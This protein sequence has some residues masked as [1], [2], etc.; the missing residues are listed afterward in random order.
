MK[1]YFTYLAAGLALILMAQSARGQATPEARAAALTAIRQ[2][3]AG[4]GDVDAV[5]GKIAAARALRGEAGFDRDLARLEEL[6]TY[7]LRFWEHAEG[8]TKGLKGTEELV[9]GEQRVAV[10]ESA[11]GILVLRVAGQNKS[12]TR[13]TMPARLVLT[14]A[15][16]EL[17]AAD[18][19]TKVHIGAFLAL[20]GRGDRKL[21]RQYWDEAAKAGLDV[22]RL[23][24]ELDVPQPPLPA[25]P[26]PMSPALR[27]QLA[28]RNFALRR[29]SG[30][31]WTREPSG[32]V[33]TQNAE[34]RLELQLPAGDTAPVQV[35]SKRTF[36]GD[37][38]AAM[39]VDSKDQPLVVG[40]YAAADGG[41]GRT[42]SVPAGV[43]LVTITK[44]MGKISFQ[45]GER[46]VPATLLAEEKPRTPLVLGLQLAPGQ[47]A[48]LAAI[49]T[50]GR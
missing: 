45:V 7:A 42:V 43:Y 26:P 36:A 11:N 49:E 35:I 17:N 41:V 25:T 12:Y 28:E 13:A 44:A 37:F 38:Q 30:E 48:T 18:P 9:V 4:R 5:N 31:A 32:N 15:T 20:D 16:R 34:G 50:A 29:K 19:G 8:V 24:P 14:L 3:A 2:A 47:S 10:V 27:G 46:D 6:T 33:L 40:V 21:A 23:L 1:Q 39:V 22:A